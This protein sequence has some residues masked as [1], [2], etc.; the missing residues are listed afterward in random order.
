MA[1][2]LPLSAFSLAGSPAAAS[3][4]RTETVVLAAE[5]QSKVHRPTLERL[6]RDAA[7]KGISLE[8]AVDA[9][10]AQ[11]AKTDPA[12]T[13]NWPDGPVDIPDVAIDDLSAA[14]IEVL[15]GMAQAQGVSFSEAIERHGSWPS[16]KQKLVQLQQAF[17]GEFAGGERAA[18]GSH[19]WLGFKGDIPAP[20]IETAKTLP[21][22]VELQGRLGYTEAELNDTKKRVHHAL[23]DDPRFSDVASYY[24][25]KT[26][27]VHSLVVPAP[28]AKASVQD[29]A[30][31]SAVSSLVTNPSITVDVTVTDGPV[32]S[33][34]SS[35][36]TSASVSTSAADPYIRGGGNLGDCTSNFNVV[37][38]WDYETRRHG[39]AGHCA[40]GASTRTYC[41][42]SIDG[43]NCTG[44]SLTNSCWLGCAYGEAALY[45]RGGLTL[46]RTFY[47]SS[48]QKAYVDAED[49]VQWVGDDVCKWGKSTGTTCGTV[50]RTNWSNGTADNLFVTDQ[51][52]GTE[53]DHGDSGGPAF[54]GGPSAGFTAY[55][56]VV[57]QGA[58]VGQTGLYC[59][60]S[61]VT[62]YR[63]AF[64]YRIWNRE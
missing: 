57:G 35:T 6:K 53:C 40:N 8:Q 32:A 58:L 30:V 26:G 21:L 17:K 14:H 27:T 1:L 13:A 39:T 36:A 56:I 60:Y 63:D 31:D 16:A 59:A 61:H 12:A 29:N 2:L 62:V 49:P 37:A 54:M 50:Q 45:T 3:P 44:I 20:A 10:I 5:R 46:T 48:N 41:N 23:R 22:R 7:R 4:A 52:A 64:G 19:V 18:D 55:G 11:K 28:A 9:Y 38:T 25:A 42:Y 15:K 43:G 51:P 33:T 24:D 34:F 47:W